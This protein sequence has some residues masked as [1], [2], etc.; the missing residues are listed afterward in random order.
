MRGAASLQAKVGVLEVSS[1]WV[2]EELT[3]MKY[4]LVRQNQSLIVGRWN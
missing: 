4:E 1:V 2:Q 3:R